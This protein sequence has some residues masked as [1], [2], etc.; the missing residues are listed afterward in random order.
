MKKIALLFLTAAVLLGISSCEEP[1]K[2]KEYKKTDRHY[3][4]S[5]RGREDRNHQEKRW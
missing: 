3:R 5:Y 1:P 4:D 2:K